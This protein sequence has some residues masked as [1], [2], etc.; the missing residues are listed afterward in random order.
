MGGIGSP[1]DRAEDRAEASD[2][3]SSRSD[4][5]EGVE[6]GSS[7]GKRVSRVVVVL[8]TWWVIRIELVEEEKERGKEIKS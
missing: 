6:G 1:L 7:G 5:S 4:N 3:S 2:L 8:F